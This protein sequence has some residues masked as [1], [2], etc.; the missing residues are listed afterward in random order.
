[1]AEAAFAA[2]IPY[3]VVDVG[4]QT[5][6]RQMDRRALHHATDKN[7]D[8]DIVY[9]N[10]DHTPATLFYLDMREKPR[11]AYRI[12]YWHWEQTKFPDT[13]MSGFDGL[14]EIWVP[15][16]FVQESISN[17][18][19]IPVA[20]M[21]HA[22]S[23]F[24]D[25]KWSRSTFGIPENKFAVLVMYDFNSYGYRKNPEAA[26]A[27]FRRGLGGRRDV[28]L[29]IK[30]IDADK[31]PT[32]YASLKQEIGDLECVV[33]LDKTLSREQV[34]GLEVNCDCLLSL[35][36]AEGYG[37]S[38]AEMMYLGKPVIATGW[39]GNMEFMTP[40]NSFPVNY[41]LKPLAEPV[42]VYAAGPEWAEP[43]IEHAAKCL[44]V[45][46]ENA[47]LAKEIGRR[48]EHTIRSRFSPVA[49]GEKYKDRLALIRTML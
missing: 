18:S 2:D 14:D 5:S 3:S 40:M 42:G 9:V 21:P 49:I 12:G 47:V 8:I 29:V 4:F 43:D 20:K 45:V 38:I 48:A 27:A 36:R 32:E 33:L 24:V 34:Y 1:M 26:I 10:A 30:T 41:E 13:F 7:Y 11:A 35:H 22:V 25:A 39:S 28:C 6:H 44:Y 16:A 37:L 19:P 17:V 23:F 15:T 46:I 31:Y